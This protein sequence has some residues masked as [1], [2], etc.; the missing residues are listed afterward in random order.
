MSSSVSSCCLSSWPAVC[1][2]YIPACLA[3]PAVTLDF[4]LIILVAFDHCFCCEILYPIKLLVKCLFF[5]VQLDLAAENCLEVT[6]FISKIH[7][8]ETEM[9]YGNTWGIFYSEL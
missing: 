9:D 8:C 7:R 6:A 3:L 4:P 1:A 2:L 5:S